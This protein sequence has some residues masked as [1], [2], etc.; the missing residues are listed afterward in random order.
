[1]SD[2]NRDSDFIAERD[3]AAGYTS[4]ADGSNGAE[5]GDFGTARNVDSDS[6]RADSFVSPAASVPT[7]RIQRND[8]NGIADGSARRTKR[9]TI[10][11]R[12]RAGRNLSPS[13]ASSN[14]AAPVKTKMV[15][16]SDAILSLHDLA[17]GIFEIDELQIDENDAKRL[18]DAVLEVSKY[19]IDAFDPKKVAYFNLAMVAGGIYGTR[20]MAYRRRME[21]ERAKKRLSVMP[22]AQP[23]AAAPPTRNAATLEEYLGGMPPIEGA[24][25]L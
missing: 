19:H 8:G 23:P 25:G 7:D 16:L 10:D 22:N 15:S 6:S 13:E 20:V 17:A 2:A 14:L 1:M 5:V 3:D 9:G 12:T 11:R 21:R 18:S 24:A 4:V